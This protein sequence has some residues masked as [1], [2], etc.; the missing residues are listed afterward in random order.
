MPRVELT[1]LECTI[2]GVVWRR[3]PCS[4]YLVGKEFEV[5][6]SSQWSASAGSIYPA[7]QRLERAGFVTAHKEPWGR[8]GRSEFRLSPAGLATLTRWIS[9]L[10]STLATPTPDPI[11]TRLFFLDA[12]S[13]TADRQAALDSALALTAESLK[14][15]EALVQ[16]LAELGPEAE[17]L[18]ALG[19]V[20]ELEA[21]LRWLQH[22]R[23]RMAI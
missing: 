23:S 16:E 10:D 5:S 11:R 3:Q 2:L 6:Q 8:N 9:D 21:R 20:F 14:K 12:L 15:L 1:E 22:I 19:G 7:L 18:A 13:D 17:H 4:A